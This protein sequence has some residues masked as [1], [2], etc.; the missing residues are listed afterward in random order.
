M[1]PTSAAAPRSERSPRCA[2]DVSLPV[3]NNGGDRQ[4]RGRAGGSVIRASKNWPKRV[5]VLTLVHVFIIAHIVHWIMAGRTTTPIEPSEAMEFTRTGAINM[6]LIF[7]AVALLST[8]IL[9]RWFCG[10]GCHVVFLQDGCSWIMKKLGVKPKPFR[11]RLL[12]YV[13][14]I[15]AVYMFIM[16]AVHRWGLIPL[17]QWMSDRLSED[18]LV[19]RSA[20]ASTA[21][22]GFPMHP[23]QPLPAW[24]AHAHLT[25]D[26]FWQTFPGVAVAIP[27]L[28]ICGFGC[29]YFLGSKGFCTYGCPYG[30]FF[31][32]VDELSPGRIRVTDDCEQC[33]HC[34]AVCTSN[35][36]VHEEVREYGMV[37]DPGCM[38]CLDCVSVCPKNALYFGFGKPA[39]GK[40]R[41]KSKP[42]LKRYDLSWPE[43]IACALVFLG[44]F[45]AFRGVYG[46]IP[47]LM[48]VGIA[49]VVTFMA[50]KLWRIIRDANVTFLR[51]RLRI[52]SRVTRAGWAFAVTA[53]FVLLLTVHSGAVRAG[54]AVAAHFDSK[55]TISVDEALFSDD[56]SVRDPF[57]SAARRGLFWYHFIAAIDPAW[58]GLRHPGQMEYDVRRAWLHA[59]LGDLDEADRLLERGVQR[60]GMREQYAEF[61]FMIHLSRG[62][63]SEAFSFAE[64]VLLEHRAMHRVLEQFVQL[65]HQF[66]MTERAMA[67]CESRLERFP[68]DVPTLQWL[69][70]LHM[71]VG[72][73][74]R[75]VE[76]L[77]RAV[78]LSP[79]SAQLRGLLISALESVGRRDEAAHHRRIAAEMVERG[80]DPSEGYRSPIAD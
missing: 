56:E 22:I 42:L 38:K 15:L 60:D 35:V 30:G 6:G 43:E 8:L 75:G 45:L 53:V 73:S 44:T 31:A 33:G 20:R 63:G 72:E 54:H 50:W 37:V 12:I 39:T 23:P 57:E 17:D 64:S 58:I 27:F 18:A 5:I 67:L 79:Q 26:D 46:L 36:R 77:E 65:T 78:E 47:M 19:L 40:G 52:H 48:A 32:P 49:G 80:P 66:G 4:G 68:D 10:W 69:A 34:T 70:L 21:A 59:V 3:V 76:L 29:V 55:V 1:N 74:T 28:L 9:G 11:S 24:Q 25:T 14:L 61:M 7:F 2:G 62:H 51:H 41:P 16:P 71:D 13:P